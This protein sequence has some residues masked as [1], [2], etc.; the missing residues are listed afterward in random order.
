LSYNAAFGPRQF[1]Y[2]AALHKAFKITESSTL[3]FRAEAFNVMNH[4]NFSTPQNTMT[5]PNFG[6]ILAGSAG[7]A[8]QLALTYAF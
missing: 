5:T 8:F 3:T 1:S 2:D 7:R 4:V 6:V